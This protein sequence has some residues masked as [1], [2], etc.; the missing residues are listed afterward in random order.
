[1][2][3]KRQT[4]CTRD[5]WCTGSN[6]GADGYRLSC[7]RPREGFPPGGRFGSTAR[8]QRG[9]L[10]GLLLT[11]TYDEREAEAKR[12][13]VLYGYDQW[14]GRNTCGFVMSRA[15]RKR[16]YTTTDRMYLNRQARGGK[17]V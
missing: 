6:S 11:G 13:M 4:I 15:A 8:Y 2:N 10:D 14:H 3:P 5:Q 1:M 9:Q 7:F 16:G 12:L 17:R